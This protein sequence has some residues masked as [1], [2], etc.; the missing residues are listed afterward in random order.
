MTPSAKSFSYEVALAWQGDRRSEISA[1][2]RT[3]IL[4]GPPPDFPLGET[5]RWSP[6]HL[7]LASISSCTMLSFL[8]HAS[9]RELVVTGYTA[10]ATGVVTRRASDGRYAFVSV[11]LHPRVT[12]SAGQREAAEALTAKAERDCFI[13][14]S[15]N[16]TVTTTWE[17][18]EG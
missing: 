18:D 1:G 15:T 16:A 3:A 2:D 5:D 8:A 7:F 9:H 4:S 13:S 14:A 12:M 17:I 11:D 6:E 10:A